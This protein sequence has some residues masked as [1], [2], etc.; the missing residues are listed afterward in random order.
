MPAEAR[1]LDTDQYDGLQAQRSSVAGY[2]GTQ[3]LPRL[4]GA[5]RAL[6][7]LLTGEPISAQR[8][9]EIGLVNAVYPQGELIGK[10][11][12]MMRKMLANGPIALKLTIE[13]VNY[14]TQMT[15][16]EALNLEANLFG[17]SCTTDDMKEGT[18]AFL[19]KRA[20]KFQ[21]K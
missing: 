10:A 17:L 18:R 4:V 19:E 6:E 11:E 15:L 1:Y 16:Q 9:Y 13:A 8:A 5:G 2:G 20:A 7:L 3:R 14:G 21:N 12:D